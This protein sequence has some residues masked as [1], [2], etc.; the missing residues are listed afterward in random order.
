MLVS[1]LD[2]KAYPW[3]NPISWLAFANPAQAGIDPVF[4]GR[5]SAMAKA[6]G[7]GIH[8][9]GNGGARDPEDQVHA[10]IHSGGHMTND[11]LWTGGNGTAA[12]PGQS[13][14][15]FRLAIDT[16]DAWLKAL[17]KDLATAKQTELLKFGLYKPLTKGNGSSVC[18]DWHIQPIELRGRSGA[19]FYK[20]MTPLLVAGSVAE[21]QSKHGL[22][23]DNVYGPDTAQKA[24]EVFK[25]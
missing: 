1:R 16:S 15:E 10:Y 23:P 4:A 19:A 25:V 21:F 12:K 7:K 2:P 14:H 22:K 20:T 6:W 18:E 24:R 9:T 8:I 3:A 13:P 11:G 17:Q 5:L